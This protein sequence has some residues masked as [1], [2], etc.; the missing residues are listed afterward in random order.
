MKK[1]SSI[2][3]FLFINVI[4]WAIGC[5]TTWEENT[6]YSLKS[7]NSPKPYYALSEKT[8]I[9]HVLPISFTQNSRQNYPDYIKRIQDSGFGNAIWNEI[10]ARLMDYGGFRI[11]TQPLEEKEYRKLISAKQQTNPGTGQRLNEFPDYVIIPNCNIF[12]SNQDNL[13]GLNSTT[14]LFYQMQIYL[15]LYKME[16]G[17]INNPVSIGEGKGRRDTPLDAGTDGCKNAVADLI[18]KSKW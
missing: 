4:L 6:K 5:G 14:K 8:N 9:V 18:S 17:N 15:H 3:I 2:S 13:T 10:E 12:V 7:Q 11:V 16:E 1:K